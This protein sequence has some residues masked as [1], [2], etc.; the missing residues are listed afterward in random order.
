MKKLNV[1]LHLALFS[2]LLTV[3]AF[4]GCSR[5]QEAMVAQTASAE[6]DG[7]AAPEAN[8]HELADGVYQ[9]IGSFNSVLV[10]VSGQEVLITDP[11][12][13]W[14]AE[15]LKA[16]IATLTESPVSHIV[17]THE[18]H[19]HIGGTGVFPEAKVY[20]H[21]NALPI[22]ALSDLIPTPE[23]DETYTEFLSIP[24]G[25]KTVELHYLGP[26]DGDA[27]TVVYMPNEKIVATADM[28]EDKQITHKY[29]IDDKNFTGTRYILNTISEWDVVHAV[30]A[31]SP[32]TDPQVLR[33]NAQYYNDLY[34]ATYAAMTE[35]MMAEGIP[36]VIGL[37]DTLPTTLQL[38]QYESWQNYDTSFPAHVERMLLSI[39]HGD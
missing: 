21:V 12:N 23:V 25:D 1:G 26:G 32:S 17:L 30:N 37:I 6:E 8:F 38:E 36:A 19:D 7:T 5:A 16:F 14:Q 34:D 35:A 3:I 4:S 13:D 9:W 31:H 28:Y 27:T 33:D 15:P 20:V 11:S 2:I 29:W 10:V 18:H 24:V 39:F 22:F